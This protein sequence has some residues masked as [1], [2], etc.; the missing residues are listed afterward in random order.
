[1][2]QAP[3]GTWYM[4]HLCSRPVQGCSILG[5]ETAI[6]NIIWTKEG[7]FQI[8]KGGRLPDSEFFVLEDIEENSAYV[9][10]EGRF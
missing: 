2:V 1:M 7:W 6:Q 8:Q 10:G 4:A 9:F 5:R 3:D